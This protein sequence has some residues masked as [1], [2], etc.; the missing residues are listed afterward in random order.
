MA[1]ESM[2]DKQKIP[3]FSQ[4]FRKFPL[5]LACCVAAAESS[6]KSVGVNLLCDTMY[7]NLEPP[8]LNIFES[9]QN[10][11]I[12]DLDV[13]SVAEISRFSVAG[14]D[15][16][17]FSLDQVSFQAKKAQKLRLLANWAYLAGQI[18]NST[19][20]SSGSVPDFASKL[21]R[22]MGNIHTPWGNVGESGNCRRPEN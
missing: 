2:Q 22:I 12:L 14:R 7:S 20:Q 21:A 3:Q 11:D 4:C 13:R 16:I 8:R 19:A 17:N 6:R 18:C 10:D 15:G 1:Q 9:Q 5:C